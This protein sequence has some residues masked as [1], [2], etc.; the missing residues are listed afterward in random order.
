MLKMKLKNQKGFT[1]IEIIAVLVILGIL[2]AVAIPK[3]LD[4][5][6]QAKNSAAMSAVASAQSAL[7]MGY[8]KY[9]LANSG[10]APSMATLVGAVTPNCGVSNSDFNVTCSS[11]G[12]IS[13]TG[14]TGTAAAGGT[15]G[16]TYVL[17]L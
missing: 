8:S 2:A 12:V 4:L 1:L 9:I 11:T 7:T 5:Q 16:G 6:D 13:A 10:S 14:K 17:P 15:A 3:Y